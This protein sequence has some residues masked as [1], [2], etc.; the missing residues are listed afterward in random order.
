MNI[1]LILQ[2]ASEAIG[3]R[4][5]FVSGSCR[6][7]FAD[8]A[9]MAKSVAG[10][11]KA[12]EK[13]GFLSENTPLMPAALFG[14]ALVGTQ[15]VPLNYRLAESQLEA[16]LGR[17][18]PALLLTDKDIEIDGIRAITMLQAGSGDIAELEAHPLYCGTVI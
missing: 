5:A 10:Q 16:Q 18:S 11:V 7:T 8:L 13:I 14:A 2:M 15:F 12:G 17:I 6:G 4:E 9:D 3:H 1:H